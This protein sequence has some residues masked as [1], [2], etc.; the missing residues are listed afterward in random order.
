MSRRHPAHRSRPRWVAVTGLCTVGAVV[1][2]VVGLAVTAPHA[3]D[4]TGTPT[5][6]ATTPSIASHTVPRQLAIPSIGVRKKLVELSVAQDRTMELPPTDGV[7]WYDGSASPG[8][9]GAAVVTG[10]IRVGG[11]RGALARLSEL[12]PGSKVSIL[13][14]DGAYAIYTVDRIDSYSPDEFPVSQVYGATTRPTL[15]IVTTGGTLRP[16]DPAGNVVVYGSLSRIQTV[17]NESVPMNKKK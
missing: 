11:H 10:F 16:G 2:G 15:R 7:G 1:A 12:R 6:A 9:P 8:D 13:R 5:S 3:S 14:S 4:R 17:N